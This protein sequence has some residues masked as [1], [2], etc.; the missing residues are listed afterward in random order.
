MS[1]H[2]LV[3]LSLCHT[4]FAS[5]E[6][7]LKDANQIPLYAQETGVWCGAASAQMMLEGFP[8]GEDHVYKQ[9]YIWD[10]IQPLKVETSWY[11]DPD[12]LKRVMDALGGD[13]NW[14]ARCSQTSA[15][16]MKSSLRNLADRKYPIAVLVY[17]SAHWIVLIGATTDANPGTSDAINLEKVEA[18]DP[19]KAQHVLVS[20]TVWFQK[21]WTKPARTRG[22]WSG[23]YV[24]IQE[25][26]NTA[27]DDRPLEIRVKAPTTRGIPISPQESLRLARK[28]L[29]RLTA[30]SSRFSAL[31]RQ[32]L[33]APKLVSHDRGSYYL[34]A[35]GDTRSR[36]TTGALMLNAYT[37]EWEG[38]SQFEKTPHYAGERSAQGDWFFTPS[39]ESPSPFFP[40]YRTQTKGGVSYVSFDGKTHAELHPMTPGS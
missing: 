12:G 34:I 20:G 29:E 16:L 32:A 13:S 7:Y 8:N 25:N 22:K 35:L 30:G 23:C 26:T 21:Y 15:P 17:G 4:A 14:E 37:G 2:L 1:K 24:A 9:K 40:L 33:F 5:F 3:L 11:T 39:Q 19:W 18:F 10:T 38:L 28:H 27:R 36:L 6:V 31:S